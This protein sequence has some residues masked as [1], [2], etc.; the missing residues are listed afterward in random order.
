MLEGGIKKREGK[1]REIIRQRQPRSAQGQLAARINRNP[2]AA[3]SLTCGA[4]PLQL[5]SQRVLV[6]EEIC[7]KLDIGLFGS[8]KQGQRTY[9]GAVEPYIQPA[10]VGADERRPVVQV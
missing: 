9:S 6:G 8:G 10:F 1:Q 4:V 5:Q 3:G 7:R 2:C